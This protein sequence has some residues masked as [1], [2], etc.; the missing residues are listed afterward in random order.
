[1]KRLIIM[2]HGVTIDKAIE[3]VE[4]IGVGNLL[5]DQID[6][7]DIIVETGDYT[8]RLTTK[9]RKSIGIDVWKPKNNDNGRVMV[10]E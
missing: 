9:K 5:K 6:D 7:D 2:A 10:V 3:I 4:L 1:M 8:I